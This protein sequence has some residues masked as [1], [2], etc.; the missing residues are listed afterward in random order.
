M[1][2]ARISFG[3]QFQSV[4][5]LGPDLVPLFHLS[6]TAFGSL[7]GAFMFMGVFVALPL[8]VLGRRFGD[9]PVLA[10]GLV[11]MIVGAIFDTTASGPAGIALGRTIG[12]VGAVAMIVLQGKII[13]DFFT[14]TRFMIGISVS[15][16]A[17]PVGVGLAQI[18][19]PPVSH[20][21]GWQTALLTEAAAPA[22]ALLLFLASYRQPHAVA[23][24]SRGF[25]WPTR[26]ECPLVI[27]AGS[28]WTAYTTG[29][30]G[31]TSYVPTTLAGRGESVTMIGL[32]LVIATWGNVPATM[33]GG[34]L[35]ARFGGLRI[36]LLGNLALVVGMAGTA[37]TG[38]PGTGLSWSD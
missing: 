23:A 13:A 7:I 9:R 24:Q 20:A 11:L 34:G 31:Y 14:G 5:T 12:G 27:I 35:A 22:L 10:S 26:R 36:F 1:A 18:V 6:Y 37:V 30:S 3:Y 2:L 15:A 17:F 28:I 25:A 33:F 8:G 29:Y 38:G 16:C 21:F 19:L 32:V 4:A